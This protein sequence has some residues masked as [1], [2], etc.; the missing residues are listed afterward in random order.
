MIRVLIFAFLPQYFAY[1]VSTTR[2]PTVHDWNLN[3]PV[4]V[5]WLNAY[6]PVG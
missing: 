3:G 4:P 6:D 5:G 1:L 2:W